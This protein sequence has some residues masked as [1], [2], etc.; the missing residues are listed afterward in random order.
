MLFNLEGAGCVACSGDHWRSI[1]GWIAS[2]SLPECFA[3]QRTLLRGDRPLPNLKKLRIK[4]QLAVRL[5]RCS[6]PETTEAPGGALSNLSTVS[7]LISNLPGGSSY[8]TD[9]LRFRAEV[10][11]LS[12]ISA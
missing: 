11:S 12:V 6:Y 1:R 3:L 2:T 9:F 10:H 8:P 7:R 4:P 5:T